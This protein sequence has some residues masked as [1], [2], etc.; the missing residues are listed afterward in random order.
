MWKFKKIKYCWILP[1]MYSYTLFF[2]DW[3]CGE[4]SLMLP[5]Y[6]I[7]NFYYVYFYILR[8]LIFFFVFFAYKLWNE[9]DIY[10]SDRE[11]FPS[12]LPTT[13]SSSIWPFLFSYSDLLTFILCLFCINFFH[14]LMALH[15]NLFHVKKVLEELRIYCISNHLM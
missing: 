6:D 3:E 10:V 8:H 1:N 11:L 2:W 14:T 12:D 9:E 7:L 15:T 5:V 4:I 13:N